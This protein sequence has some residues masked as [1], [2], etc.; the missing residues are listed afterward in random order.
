MPQIGDRALEV[1]TGKSKWCSFTEGALVQLVDDAAR[2]VRLFL[3][4]SQRK[5]QQ[6]QDLRRRRQR[7]RNSV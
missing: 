7:A 2:K 6:L 4:D 3:S 5:S 1:K